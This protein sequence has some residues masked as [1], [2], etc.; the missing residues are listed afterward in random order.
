MSNQ[1][2]LRDEFNGNK[3][4]CGSEKRA[5]VTFCGKCF[6][7]LPHNIRIMLRR[8]LGEGYEEAYESAVQFLVSLE[9]KKQAEREDARTARAAR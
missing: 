8:K 2:R 7:A 6:Y 1:R 5:Y 3:C 9:I 4:R